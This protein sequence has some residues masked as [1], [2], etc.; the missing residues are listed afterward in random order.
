[1][2]AL[3]EPQAAV[4]DALAAGWKFRVNVRAGVLLLTDGR[5]AMTLRPEVTAALRSRGLIAEVGMTITH[6]GRR[7]LKA[8]KAR[9]A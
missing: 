6:D 9:G 4:L 3:S 1:M 5:R 8:H 7:A 2:E